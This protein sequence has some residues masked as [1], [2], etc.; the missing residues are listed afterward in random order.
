MSKKFK[1]KLQKRLILVCV[2]WCA[3]FLLWSNKAII[4]YHIEQLPQQVIRM[5]MPMVGV[6]HFYKPFVDICGDANL[7]SSRGNVVTDINT[8]KL[9]HELD[10][11]HY[12]DKSLSISTEP[13]KIYI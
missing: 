12:F 6:D 11:H 3:I 13:G 1:M 5:G 7:S 10:K 8:Y 4:Q 9:I 2:S